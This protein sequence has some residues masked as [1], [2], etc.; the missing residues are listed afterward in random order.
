[1]TG[2]ERQLVHLGAGRGLQ[3]RPHA[4]RRGDLVD[5]PD[6]GQDRAVEVGQRDEPVLDRESA[7][8]HP[9]VGD[10]L[11]DE[12]RHRGSGPGDPSLPLQE[13]P[14]ALARQQRLA[15][16]KLKQE[17]DLVAQR[18]DRIE[19][20]E[21]VAARPGRKAPSAK[22]IGEQLGGAGGELLGKPERH[23][24]ARVDRTAER[25]QR[26]E[27]FVAAVG[28]RLV[29]EH[30]ALRVAGEVHVLAGRIADPVDRVRHRQHVI[31]QRALE[32]AG[33]ALGRAEVDHP[34]VGAVLAQDRHRAGVRSDVINLGREH[35]RRYEQDRRAAA[36][37][38]CVVVTQ[39]IHALL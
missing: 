27:A 34:R 20:L 31:C 25:D 15:V 13:A 18:L 10:E 9:V 7:L 35:Q 29:A 8:E 1:V 2:V 11:P 14:L 23:R 26:P 3:D 21:A 36:L 5:G 16:V 19:Q 37:L 38:V 4:R 17:L 33:F 28:S 12:V 30:A 6:D 32:A 39:A 22:R 24:L